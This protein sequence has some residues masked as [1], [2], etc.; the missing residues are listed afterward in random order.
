M[1]SH[2]LH[3]PAQTQSAHL[4]S[5]LLHHLL[6]HKSNEVK[7]LHPEVAKMNCRNLGL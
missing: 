1:Y 7:N 5:E 6:F 4:R 3:F 2:L